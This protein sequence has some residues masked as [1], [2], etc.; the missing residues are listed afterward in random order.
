MI[1]F[2]NYDVN[3]SDVYVVMIMMVILNVCHHNDVDCHD[4]NYHGDNDSGVML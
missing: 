3:V 2:M 1:W 4:G